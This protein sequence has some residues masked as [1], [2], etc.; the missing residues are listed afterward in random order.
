MLYTNQILNVK[1]SVIRPE[2]PFIFRQL[3]C[4]PVS[5]ITLS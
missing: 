5:G 1:K 2:R 3:I 4:F